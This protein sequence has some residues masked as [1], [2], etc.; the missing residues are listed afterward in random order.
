MKPKII[1]AICIVA[2]GA[3]LAYDNYVREESNDDSSLKTSFTSLSGL[4]ATQNSQ[5]ALGKI[6]PTFTDKIG[7]DEFLKVLALK[8]LAYTTTNIKATIN[9]DLA[10]VSY[11]RHEEREGDCEPIDLK[12]IGE[13]WIK[14]KGPIPTWKLYKLA[15]NDTSLRT[16][17]CQKKKKAPPITQ[18]AVVD[19]S[20]T[21]AVA[22]GLDAKPM[23]KG[24]RY[25]PSG[26]R[27]PFKPL[28]TIGSTDGEMMPDELC[29]PGRDKELLERFELD[30][31]K[32]TG[33][34]LGE[35]GPLALIETPDGNGYTV[36]INMYLGKRCGKIFKMEDKYI[37]LKEQV[38]KPGGMLGQFVTIET[39]VR[40]RQEEEDSTPPKEQIRKPGGISGQSTTDSPMRLR[41]EEG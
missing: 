21:T 41:R 30:I 29:E 13:T 11:S 31:L 23:K 3:Y 18:V 37:L 15:D 39:P 5:M 36:S 28:I 1:I 14:D 17:D 9:G 16:L 4:I 35:N 7:K 27:D 32:L 2:I 40:L 8:R 10:Q 6:S 38:R 26:K 25:N 22:K 34:I 20:K 12:I 33:I 24:E 19:A